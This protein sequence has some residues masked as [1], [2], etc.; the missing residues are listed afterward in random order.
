M[1]VDKGASRLHWHPYSWQS[2]FE[3]LPTRT[4]VMCAYDTGYRPSELVNSDTL[5]SS[6]CVSARPQG[7]ESCIIAYLATKISAGLLAADA[8]IMIKAPRLSH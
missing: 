8:L 7:R 4:A 2:D 6:P 1:G 5:P 3:R